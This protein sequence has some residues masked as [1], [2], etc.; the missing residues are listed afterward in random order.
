VTELFIALVL[1]WTVIDGDT[2]DVRA[3]VSPGIIIEERVRLVRVDAPEIHRPAADCEIN[4]GK[5]AAEWTRSQLSATTKTI[6]IRV[7][8]KRDSFGR[9]LG[10]VFVNGVSLSDAGVAAGYYRPYAD[11]LAGKVWC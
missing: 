3:R 10:D 1:T 2:I 11:R 4:K 7:E 8:Q 5:L 9:L 6:V